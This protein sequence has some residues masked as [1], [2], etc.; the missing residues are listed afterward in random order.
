MV[1]A[2]G[3]LFPEHANPLL[4]ARV[5][6]IPDDEGRPVVLEV[7]AHQA[8]VLLR[9]RARVGRVFADALIRRL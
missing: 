7:E 8:V 9:L 1:A 4:Y 6:L 5:D 3:E 2:L